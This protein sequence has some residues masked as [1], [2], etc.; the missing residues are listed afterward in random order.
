MTILMV[1]I[2][3]VMIMR[4]DNCMMHIIEMGSQNANFKRSACVLGASNE[5]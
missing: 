3:V 1:I 2:I 5:Y 4:L